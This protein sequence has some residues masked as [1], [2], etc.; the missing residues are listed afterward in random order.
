MFSVT[1]W[2]NIN[3]VAF[4]FRFVHTCEGSLN[5]LK[6]VTCGNSEFQ[7]MRWQYTDVKCV[8]HQQTALSIFN[9]RR[10]SCPPR[11]IFQMPQSHMDEKT[12]EPRATWQP[13]AA[14]LPGSPTQIDYCSRWRSA[15]VFSFQMSLMRHPPCCLF[16]NSSS[17]WRPH[18]FFFF[19]IVFIGQHSW[20]P[21]CLQKWQ[22]I[23]ARIYFDSR[24]WF[25][26]FFLNGT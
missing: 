14:A 15:T 24:G 18:S 5:I 21:L 26:P 1:T 2:V 11:L 12:A 20:A 9:L 16:T 8:W 19:Y 22:R 6:G 4:C 17:L 10:W 13:L 7:S 23:P 3:S 25:T